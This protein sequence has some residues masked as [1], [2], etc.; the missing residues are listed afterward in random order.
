[1]EIGL[2][3]AGVGD[4]HRGEEVDVGAEVPTLAVG[5]AALVVVIVH[6]EEVSADVEGAVAGPAR[7]AE[8]GAH[9]AFV[10]FVIEDVVAGEGAAIGG[11]VEA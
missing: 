3:V 10:L 6:G 7:D 4:G 9:D 2:V 5:H 11:D 8:V 1:M